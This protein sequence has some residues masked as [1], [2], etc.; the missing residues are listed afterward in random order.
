MRY[1]PNRMQCPHDVSENN[2]DDFGGCYHTPVTCNAQFCAQLDE[3]DDDEDEDNGL[4]SEEEETTDD[5]EDLN[6]N[7]Q[8][9]AHNDADFE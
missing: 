9:D 1:V 8:T 7:V 5:E 2:E 3:F 4:S 6:Q